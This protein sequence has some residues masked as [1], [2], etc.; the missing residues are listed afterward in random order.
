[1]GSPRVVPAGRIRLKQMIN[2]AMEH[3][4]KV[5]RSSSDL[6]AGY[7]KDYAFDD[8]DVGLRRQN[9]IRLVF[10]EFGNLKTAMPWFVY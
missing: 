10:D 6:R 1:M 2:E 3:G 7:Y 9:G 8:V 4:T 5:S